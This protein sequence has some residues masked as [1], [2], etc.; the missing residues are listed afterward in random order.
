MSF[1]DLD[2]NLLPIFDAVMSEQNLSRAA[3]RLAMRQPAVSLALKRLRDMLDDEL[4]VRTAHGV[5]PTPRAEEL[6]PAVRLALASLESVIVPDSGDGAVAG[7]TLRVMLLDSLASFVLPPLM[8][9]IQQHAP[10]LDL[11]VL[12]LTTR[13]PRAMLMQ[14][15]V[16]LAIG[17]FPQ[18]SGE[19]DAELAGVPA[20]SPVRHQRLYHGEAV[21]IMRPGHPL[22]ST[23]LTLERFCAAS[24]V[25]MS[26]S[27]KAYWPAEPALAKL[28]RERRIALTVN[29]FA[30]IGQVVARSDLLAI[31]P[32]DLIEATGMTGQVVA[33]PLPFEFAPLQVDM[34]W[35]QRDQ[36]NAA[37]VWL[38][39]TL[40]AMKAPAP[41]QAPEALSRS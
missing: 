13:D 27:G 18:L 12:P 1:V 24:H 31:L 16:D 11:Q 8:G 14:N 35:H 19:I 33:R 7:G 5:R 25:L 28:G 34:L 39:E 17:V 2:L 29:Q 21:C 37:H 41:A 15:Q 36:R 4:L 30:T 10:G 26:L 6:W 22:A 3:E 32:F 9:A 38:R 20:L 40:G 23:D